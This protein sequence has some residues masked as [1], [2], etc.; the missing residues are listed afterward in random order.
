MIR[1]PARKFAHHEPL[2]RN[3]SAE[4]RADLRFR[5]G[6]QRQRHAGGVCGALPGVIVRC[7]AD[8]AKAENDI[9]RFKRTLGV[10]R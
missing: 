3:V 2:G 5:I 6:M 7:S 9:L 8:T 4:T 1:L 10:W